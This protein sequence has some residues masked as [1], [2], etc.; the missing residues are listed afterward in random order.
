M[1]SSGCLWF[2]VFNSFSVDLI[3][4]HPLAG[5]YL[6]PFDAIVNNI[7]VLIS[8]SNSSLLLYRN[9]RDLSIDFTSCNIL[10]LAGFYGDF[11]VF[12]R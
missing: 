6:I 5:S 7:V 11:R 1:F 10:S 2:Q 12:Y 4:S 9:A 3:D 8:L